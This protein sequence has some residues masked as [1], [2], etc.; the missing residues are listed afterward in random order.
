M[1]ELVWEA[2]SG[3]VVVGR[4]CGPAGPPDRRRWQF[5]ICT[6]ADAHVFADVGRTD[7]E[8]ML[9]ALLADVRG[10]TQPGWPS[11][12]EALPA[13]DALVAVAVAARDDH[14]ERCGCEGEAC[15]L[16]AA[17]APLLTDESL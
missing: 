5:T 10:D 3:E 14:D 15:K 16:G 4:F 1:A 7:V 17:L 12:R 8:D 9:A 6:P 13:F 2:E 11:L